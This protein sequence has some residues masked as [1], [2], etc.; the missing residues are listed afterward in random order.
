MTSILLSQKHFLKNP[1]I[2]DTWTSAFA[3]DNYGDDYIVGGLTVFGDTMQYLYMALINDNGDIIQYDL[4]PQ[5]DF[6][7]SIARN[8]DFQVTEGGVYWNSIGTGRTILYNYHLDSNILSAL[9]TFETHLH[10]FSTFDFVY[11]EEENEIINVGV[12]NPENSD[13]FNF[14]LYKS[15][16]DSVSTYILDDPEKR[17]IGFRIF[18]NGDDTYTVLSQH[19]DTL[20]NSRMRVYTFDKDLNMLGYMQGPDNFVRVRSIDALRDRNGNYVMCNLEAHLAENVWDIRWEPNI[21]FLSADGTESWDAKIGTSENDNAQ[22]SGWYGITESTQNDGYVIAGSDYV[23]APQRDTMKSYATIAKISYEGDSVWYRRFS[24]I[25]T[26]WARSEFRDVVA[27][28][29]GGYMAVGFDW[30]L[31][32]FSGC[33]APFHMLVLRTNSEGLI[34]ADSISS[35]VTVDDE[36][37]EVI[38]YPN[39]TLETLYIQHNSKQHIRYTI[40]DQNGINQYDFE[41]GLSDET[42][43]LDTSQLSSGSYYLVVKDKRNRLL[44]TKLILK[45]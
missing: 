36:G 11:D 22:V 13:G 6:I 27:T 37:I 2:G 33:T 17:N 24:T 16:N 26:S 15:E 40:V 31:S 29:D 1:T 43:I 25:D 35:V 44:S 23:Y 45:I 5:N 38:A 3:I 4:Y 32:R 28:T 8:N 9:D 7:L 21:S 10:E 34:E 39:P 19:R 18:D 41:G 12:F 42:F 30:C 14:G 20:P